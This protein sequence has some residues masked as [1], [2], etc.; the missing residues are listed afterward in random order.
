MKHE[1]FYKENMKQSAMK[2][3]KSSESFIL[4]MYTQMVIDESLFKM[5]KATL[6]SAIDSAL[7]NRDKGLFQTLSTEYNKLVRAVS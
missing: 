6:L 5:R 3:Q 4:E 7:D 1:N 2:K